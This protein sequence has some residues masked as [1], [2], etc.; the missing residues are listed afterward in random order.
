MKEEVSEE[1][2]KRAYYEFKAYCTPQMIALRRVRGRLFAISAL[3][4]LILFTLVSL[5]EVESLPQMLKGL[6]H[7]GLGLRLFLIGI[8]SITGAVG[9]GT[10]FIE[11]KRTLA[12]R[13]LME[14]PAIRELLIG[15]DELAMGEALI[16][17]RDERER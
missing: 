11:F 14:N 15:G 2:L 10:Y 7:F 3:L 4:S 12:D 17:L 1:N 16:R 13:H 5:S 9:I 8:I 6:I